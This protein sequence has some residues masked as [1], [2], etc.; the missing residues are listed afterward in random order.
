M[1]EMVAVLTE[2]RRVRE[3]AVIFKWKKI[4]TAHFR[5]IV[6]QK[7]YKFM[8]RN[9]NVPSRFTFQGAALNELPV[10]ALIDS[11]NKS[12]RAW[13]RV[14]DVHTFEEWKIKIKQAFFKQCLKPLGIDTA[15]KNPSNMSHLHGCI[16]KE[17]GQWQKPLQLNPEA[18]TEEDLL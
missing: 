6:Y 3:K 11:R 9:C 2:T 8:Y 12:L 10:V 1:S 16:R 5:R 14:P 15:C 4:Y 18:G 7:I 17:T 13:I